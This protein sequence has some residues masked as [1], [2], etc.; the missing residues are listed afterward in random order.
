MTIT[1]LLRNTLE[2]AK[3][4]HAEARAEGAAAE[5]VAAGDAAA[6]METPE[7]VETETG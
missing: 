1:M 3:Q 7:A 5:G 2:A 4:L 6:R